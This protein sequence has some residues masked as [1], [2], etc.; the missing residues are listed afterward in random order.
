MPAGR[1]SRKNDR[2]GNRKA[3]ENGRKG[4]VQG[5]LPPS[6]PSCSWTTKWMSN[7]SGM[8]SLAIAV[9]GEGSGK[10]GRGEGI[11]R[12]RGRPGK[13]EGA[14][15]RESPARLSCS[16]CCCC[17]S[18]AVALPACALFKFVALYI[19]AFRCPRPRQLVLGHPLRMFRRFLSLL[20]PSSPSIPLSLGLP[21]IH[22]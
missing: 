12:R 2:K 1:T 15:V 18:T 11:V 16:C 7:R 13:A 3:W 14:P 8:L 17:C 21:S 5:D 22:A 19:F 6:R 10:G 20:L 9:D 4:R